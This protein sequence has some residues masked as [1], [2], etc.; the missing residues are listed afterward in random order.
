MRAPGTRHQGLLPEYRPLMLSLWIVVIAALVLLVGARLQPGVGDLE[1]RPHPAA[2][3]ADAVDRAQ[4][5]QAADDSVVAPGGRSILLTHERRTARAVVLLHGFTN[6]PRQFETFARQ[7]H[8][9]GDNVFVPRLPRHAERDGTASY[10]AALTA[11]ELRA[12]SDSAVDIAHGLG[13]TVIVMGLSAGGT[14]AAWIAQNRADVARVVI[15]APV[16]ELA[17]IP[18]FLSTPLMYLAL[19]APEITQNYPRD[20]SRP[21]RELGNSSHATAQILHLGVAVRRAAQDAP[22][23]VR[24]I[25]FLVNANDHTVKSTA[26]VALADRWNRSGAVATVYDLPASLGLPHDVVDE[27]QPAARTDI[28]YPVLEALAHGQHPPGDL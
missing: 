25:A 3:F 4:R 13:D 14:M 5:Q 10:L 11:E 9:A 27:T 18:S 12:S 6:S 24:D 1:S 21:D 17:R 20:K 23:R 15:I 28:V 26:A 22:P 19:R 2:D 16:L 8:A 7:L